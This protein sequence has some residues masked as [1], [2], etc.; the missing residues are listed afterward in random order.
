MALEEEFSIEIP[1]SESDKILSVAE[2]VEFLSS[3]PQAK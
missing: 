2:A 1:D 3:H